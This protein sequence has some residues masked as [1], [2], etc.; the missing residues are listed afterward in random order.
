MPKAKPRH[1]PSRPK[2]EPL[3]TRVDDLDFEKRRMIFPPGFIKEIVLKGG[4]EYVTADDLAKLVEGVINGLGPILQ[5]IETHL[6]LGSD[7]EL[8]KEE[9]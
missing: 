9:D 3:F 2:D 7:E 6:A 5:R 8:V 4:D 1:I